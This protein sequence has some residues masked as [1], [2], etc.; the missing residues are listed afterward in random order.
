MEAVGQVISATSRRLCGNC[1]AA[2]HFVGRWNGAAWAASHRDIDLSS[3]PPGLL[4]SEFAGCRSQATLSW[5]TTGA[6]ECSQWSPPVV[7][8]GTPPRHVASSADVCRETER[9]RDVPPAQAPTLSAPS[10]WS[11]YLAVTSG[12]WWGR[13]VAFGNPSHEEAHWGPSNGRSMGHGK[14][15][16]HG[17]A[18]QEG[19]SGA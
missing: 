10:C 7:C 9:S 19:Q 5:T 4:A 12:Q 3:A 16:R 14:S 6:V 2:R 8:A 11:R 15:C 1:Q 18:G 13:N 17:L